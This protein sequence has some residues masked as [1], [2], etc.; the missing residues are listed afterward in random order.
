M[1]QEPLF[2]AP[3]LV[4]LRIGGGKRCLLLS[5]AIPKIFDQLRAFGPAEF[6]KWRQFSVHA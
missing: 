3:Q 6:K 5:D 4:A 2:A 1:L